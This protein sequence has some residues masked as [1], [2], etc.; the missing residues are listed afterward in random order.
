LEALRPDTRLI[1]VGDADQLASVEAGAVLHDVVAGW[2][3]DHV[4]RLSQ[5]HRFGAAIGRLAAAVRDGDADTAVD[6]LTAGD[7]AVRLV[8][9]DHAART[10]EE[11]VLPLARDLLDAAGRGDADAALATMSTHRLLC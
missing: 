6:L 5:G 4:V 2:S 11:T 3:T 9:P 1:L 7:P 10:L 8:D